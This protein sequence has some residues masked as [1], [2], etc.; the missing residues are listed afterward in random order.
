MM[1]WVKDSVSKGYA[2]PFV[3]YRIY[4]GQQK[5]RVDVLN[6]TQISNATLKGDVF[7]PDATQISVISYDFSLAETISSKTPV[8]SAP[9]S[10]R[11]NYKAVLDSVDIG[12]AKNAKGCLDGCTVGFCK[13]PFRI[14]TQFHLQIDLAVWL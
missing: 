1:D 14:S 3:N 9:P 7:N 13:S 12:L 2:L 4:T 8:K 10:M 6:S 5:S 11:S